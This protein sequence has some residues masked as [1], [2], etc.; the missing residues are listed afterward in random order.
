MR[1]HLPP[2]DH[3]VAFYRN[4]SAVFHVFSRN[5]VRDLF[6]GECDSVQ[7]ILE[8]VHLKG[9]F[10]NHLQLIGDFVRSLSGRVESFLS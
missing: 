9:H 2:S 10:H 8:E 6:K 1:T 7:L 4:V 5:I 3:I